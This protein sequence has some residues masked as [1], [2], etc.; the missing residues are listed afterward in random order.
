MLVGTDLLTHIH[1]LA[2]TYRTPSCH[3]LRCRLK[4]SLMILPQLVTGEA[5]KIGLEVGTP[6]AAAPV[7]KNMQYM[8]QVPTW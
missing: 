5:R 1:L 7:S 3:A 4:H 2:P 8:M 6:T